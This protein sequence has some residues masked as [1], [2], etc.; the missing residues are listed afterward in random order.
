M[1][2]YTSSKGEAKDT[3]TMAYS[4]L[5]NALKKAQEEGNQENISALEEEIAIRDAE[6]TSSAS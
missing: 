5:Q 6:N 2:T 3:A 1:P 4:Y